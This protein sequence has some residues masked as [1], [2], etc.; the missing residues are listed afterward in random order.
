MKT[1]YSLRDDKKQI[2]DVQEASLSPKPFGL[3]ATQGLFGSD[4]WRQNIQTG[5]IPLIQFT[6][7][8][9]KLMRTGMHNEYPCFEMKLANG[10]TFDYDCKVM[11]RADRKLYQVGNKIKISF[12]FQ[13]LKKTIETPSGF[14]KDVRCLIEIRV[15]ESLNK[16]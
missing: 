1:V 5:K 13:P 16:T 6:G 4:I 15:E 10:E 8:I 9:T 7:I 2:A 3:K 11:N 12:V 14:Q